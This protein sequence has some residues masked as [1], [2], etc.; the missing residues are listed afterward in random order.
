MDYDFSQLNDKEFEI[1]STDLLS[2]VIGE[3]IERF[4]PGKDAGVD[5]RFFSNDGHETVIQCKHYLKSGYKALIAVAK[6][7][8]AKLPKL[9]PERYIFVTSL[10]L[11]RKNKIEI[12]SVFFPYIKGGNDIFGQEDLNDI[13][14]QN[15][16]IE[17]K[18]FK[19]WIA[20]TNVLIQIIN[21]AIKGRSEHEIE[22]IRRNADKYVVTGNH[23]EAIKILDENNVLIISGEPGI[24]KTTLAENIC[25]YFVANDYMF[26]DIE[27][28]LNEAE[29]V[30]RKGEKQI[31][32]FDDFLGSNYFEAIENKKDSHIVKFIERVKHD[33]SKKFILTSRTNILNSGIIHSSI[34]Y[35]KKIRKNEFLLVIQ[36]LTSLEKAYILYNHI[37]FSDLGIDFI[38]EIYKDRRYQNI[39]KHKNFNPRLVE[40][41]TDTDRIEVP[42]NEYWEFIVKTL[43]NPKDIWSNYFKVQ[44]NVFV[45]NLVMLTVFNGGRILEDDLRLSFNELHVIENIKNTSHTE[46]DFTLTA[47]M[48]VGSFLNRE[49]TFWGLSY[50]LFNPSITD[51]ILSE[52]CQNISKLIAVYKSLNTVESLKTLISLEKDKFI[53]TN[54]SSK[55]LDELFIYSFEKEKKIDYLIFI[56]HLLANNVE[57]RDQILKFLNQIITSPTS[58]E[59]FSEFIDLITKFRGDLHIEDLSFLLV[60]FENGSLEYY[61]LMALI[62]FGSPVFNGK[63]GQKQPKHANERS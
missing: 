11:S 45:R 16:R 54:D 19:L 26:F 33:K 4:K 34:F 22:R 60:T 5:G 52:Y 31:F 43:D 59:E 20:S 49:R 10:P 61:E 13:L 27:E 32:Y 62:N 41:I 44:S 35:N 51:F 28:N 57:K 42:V 17:E 14:A 21:N 39:I 55:I 23:N 7:E 6:K 24:G 25:L 50:S 18:H 63:P 9:K 29:Q 47:Q 1:L 2:T 8:A 53:S 3:R 58:I 37:W 56:S 46:K 12:K 40:F 30:Y 36:N 15:P 48:A 38:E